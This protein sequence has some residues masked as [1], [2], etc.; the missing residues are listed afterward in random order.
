[1]SATLANPA[2]CPTCLSRNKEE[3]TMT[4]ARIIALL[5]ALAMPF[6]LA[7]CGDDDA[8]EVEVED[9]QVEAD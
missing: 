8:G 9:G 6:T 3:L 7:G 2:A 4:L 5:L 1:M